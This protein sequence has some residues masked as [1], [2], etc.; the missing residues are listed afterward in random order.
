MPVTVPTR[1]RARALLA[2]KI[3]NFFFFSCQREYELIS[4]PLFIVVP[5]RAAVNVAGKFSMIHVLLSLSL[6]R[7][8]FHFGFFIS[9]YVVVLFARAGV[10]HHHSPIALAAAVPH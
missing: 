2:G 6:P 1:A 4:F 3:M 7:P 8:R 5:A 9:F 10:A